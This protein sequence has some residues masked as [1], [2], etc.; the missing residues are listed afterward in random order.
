[1]PA[2]IARRLVCRIGE[3]DGPDLTSGGWGARGRD[4][5][6]GEERVFGT[7]HF[8]ATLDTDQLAADGRDCPGRAMIKSR[9]AHIERP[10]A[11]GAHVAEG[12]WVAGSRSGS[13]A[14]RRENTASPERSERTVSVAIDNGGPLRCVIIP[15]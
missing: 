12:H 4:L 8:V 11:V 14:H 5:L 7:R 10:H 15:M 13:R 1:M 2:T 3:L 6:F 9:A